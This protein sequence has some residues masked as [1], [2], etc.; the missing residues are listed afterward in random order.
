MNQVILSLPSG[1]SQTA[2]NEL[3]TS[4]KGP[5]VVDATLLQPRAVDLATVKLLLEVAGAVF[6]TGTAAWTFIDKLRESLRAKN[7]AGA[8]LTLPSGKTV[9]LDAASEEKILAALGTAQS[10]DADGG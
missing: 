8:R 7:I 6:S 2:A 9:D 4:I 3:A 10:S 1:V 5:S